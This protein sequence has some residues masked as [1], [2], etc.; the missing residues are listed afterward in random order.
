VPWHADGG[1][2]LE[3]TEDIKIWKVMSEYA[4][5]SQAAATVAPVSSETEVVLGGGKEYTTVEVTR[6]H[7]SRQSRCSHCFRRRGGSTAPTVRWSR[8]SHCSTEARAAARGDPATA[9]DH[10]LY[11]KNSIDW[12]D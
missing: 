11:P 6:P 7:C 4:L 5:R 8:R 2:L 10:V 3:L 9:F 12:F 1:A